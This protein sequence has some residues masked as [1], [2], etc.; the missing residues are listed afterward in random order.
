[1][2]R[3]NILVLYTDQQ[4]WDALGANGNSNIQT[5]NLDRLVAEG[6]NF[7]RYFVQNPVCMPSRVS[8]LTGQYPSTLRI[9]RM[10]IP[11]PDDTIALP[12]MLRNY[13]YRSANIGKLHFLPHANRDHRQIHP[14]YGFD[15]LEISDE[16]GCYADAY[17]SW[18]S[19]KDP[20]QL[21]YISIGLPP[22]TE[23]W[24]Q[25]MS[26]QDEIT[27][28]E[29]RF[30][31]EAIAFRGTSD[32][33]HTAFVTEQTIKFIKQQQ[34][35][36]FLCVSGYYSPH[37]PWVAP[38]EFLDKYDPDQLQIPNFPPE[39]DQMRTDQRFSDQEL[40]SAHHGYYAMVSE[41]DH[42]VGRILSE[43]E[44][45]GLAENTIVVFTSDHGEWLGEHLRYGK[46]Y[47]GH[48]CVSRVP[49]IIRYP[50]KIDKEKKINQIVEGVDVVP[51]LLDYA[52]IPIPP[53]LQGNS[54]TKVIQND[55]P[56][57]G[58]ALMEMTGWK[59]IRTDS[60]RYIIES[61]GRESLYDLQKDPSAYQNVA[62][63]P[64][65]ASVLENH[66]LRLIRRL[67]EIER[68][69]PAIWPY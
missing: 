49:L 9:T 55:E 34:N 4:R 36:P 31:K 64:A 44:Q 37:S 53:H 26:V 1:M 5:P 17:R 27:H 68:P 16:P 51:S 59:T 23:T 35:Q 60:F 65:Y 11:V 28:P 50:R 12:K 32:V 67:I 7:S 43:L 52:G 20:D 48:D 21:D 69:L 13:G 29:D 61:D 6:A 63:D 62:K 39:V 8:F 30:P 33:T 15:H 22:A 24:H 40:R 3:P 66:R 46:G 41:V 54:L 14:D 57:N 58:V 25:Q 56:S 2:D 19:Q 45:L 47:P 38:Q 10:G 18:V 42:H